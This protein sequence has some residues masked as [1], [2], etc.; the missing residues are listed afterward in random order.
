M[1]FLVDVA[2]DVTRRLNAKPMSD[3]RLAL[4]NNRVIPIQK[5]PSETRKASGRGRVIPM[6]RA[7]ERKDTDEITFVS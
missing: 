3:R 4:V 1:L 6:P 5:E 2:V 7:N